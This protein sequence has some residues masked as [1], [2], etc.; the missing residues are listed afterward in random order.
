[1]SEG[2]IAQAIGYLRRAVNLRSDYVDAWYSLGV[3]CRKKGLLDEAINA[4][5]HTF[6]QNATTCE[7]A[8]NI[9]QLGVTLH[10]A[11]RLKE[12]ETAYVIAL[13]LAERPLFLYNMGVLLQE[14]KRFV[15]AKG[16]FEKVVALQ[17][18]NAK[19]H[20]NLGLTM[21]ETGCYKE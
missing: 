10:I 9:F 13:R 1:M 20:N 4:F 17:P 18:D 12:A 5:E 16:Y 6:K 8:E 2:D 19:A 15:E 11:G 14:Q 3:C 7:D 21:D